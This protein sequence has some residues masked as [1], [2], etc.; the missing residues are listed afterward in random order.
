MQQDTQIIVESSDK[1]LH[2]EWYRPQINIYYATCGQIELRDADYRIV[3]EQNETSDCTKGR[4]DTI[5]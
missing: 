1:L 2:R 4:T 5:N 3:M